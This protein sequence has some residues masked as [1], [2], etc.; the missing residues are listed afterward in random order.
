MRY[1][2]NFVNYLNESAEDITDLS[3]EELDELLQP[4]NMV[5][6]FEAFNRNILW[7]VQH[8]HTL[9]EHRGPHSRALFVGH[10]DL[11]A[12]G[13]QVLNRQFTFHSGV[14]KNIAGVDRGFS[15]DGQI[16][17]ILHIP[18]LLC[19]QTLSLRKKIR[20]DCPFHKAKI[21]GLRICAAIE[22]KGRR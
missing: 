19:G 11:C 9:V 4:K 10:N 13:V 6:N 15:R 18:H 1:L 2:E 22:Q 8:Y 17:A 3:K 20:C 7:Q 12:L 21:I 5:N 16:H 14:A